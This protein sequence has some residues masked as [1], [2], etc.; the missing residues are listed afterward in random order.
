MEKTMQFLKDRLPHSKGE[1]Q[2]VILECLRECNTAAVDSLV[3][4]ELLSIAGKPPTLDRDPPAC[5]V[6]RNGALD[7]D[8]NC[9]VNL[10]SALTRRLLRRCFDEMK[11]SG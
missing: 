7:C 1:K 2:T 8:D 11:A 6:C 3:L 10:R 9:A 5:T 4:K